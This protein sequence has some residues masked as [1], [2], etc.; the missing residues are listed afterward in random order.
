MSFRNNPPHYQRSRHLH[1]GRHSPRRGAW[2]ADSSTPQANADL[3][4]SSTCFDPKGT[5]VTGFRDGK[6]CPI[7]LKKSETGEYEQPIRNDHIIEGRCV[8]RLPRHTAPIHPNIAAI[9][10]QRSFST[11][12]PHTRPSRRRKQATASRRKRSICM[13]RS[14][15]EVSTF[16]GH[17]LMQIRSRT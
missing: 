4:P 17:F 16:N 5:L 13:P 11:Q 8:G 9:F 14:K 6:K 7:V 3:Q 10:S 2:S 1:K 12:S 15:R